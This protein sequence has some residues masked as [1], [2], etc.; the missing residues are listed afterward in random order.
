M[1]AMSGARA[2]R[3]RPC[4]AASGRQRDRRATSCWKTHRRARQC[5]FPH[6]TELIVMFAS[7]AGDNAGEPG[8]PE[9]PAVAE[10][11]DI[12]QAMISLVRDLEP[13]LLLLVSALCYVL[14]LFAFAQ[15]P[16]AAAENLGGQVSCALRQRHRALSFLICIVMAASAVVALGGGRK[17]VRVRSTPSCGEPRLWRARRRLRRI[18][19]GRL[20]PGQPGWVVRLHP[21]RLHAARRRRR[22]AWCQRSQGLRAHGRR[23]RRLAHRRGDRGGANQPRHR[24]P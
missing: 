10:R 4:I 17:P 6:D 22:Q 16:A 2:R 8:R 9:A 19:R 13:G 23:H 11:N 21:G 20:H 5:A 1:C 18:A 14:A 15:G 24:C 3:E 7:L 12:G